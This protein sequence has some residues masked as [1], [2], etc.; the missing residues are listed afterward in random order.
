MNTGTNDFKVIGL[1]RLGMKLE[2]T[3][4]EVDALATWPSEPGSQT[5]TG[6]L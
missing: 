4:P 5:Q 2:S 3:A 1:N 6:V